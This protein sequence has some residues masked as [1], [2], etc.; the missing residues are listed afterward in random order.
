MTDL[1]ALVR[2]SLARHADAAAPLSVDPAALAASGRRRRTAGRLIAAAAC[3]TVLGLF[4]A[5]LVNGS[6]TRPVP[7]VPMATVD[8]T[9]AG[10]PKSALERY[11]GFRTVN[12][13]AD[14]RDRWREERAITKL[15]AACMARKGFTFAVGDDDPQPAYGELGKQ[16]T[17]YVRGLSPER[18]TAFWVALLNQ[19]Q[20]AGQNQ[21]P[22]WAND[23]D[24][25]CY[26]TAASSVFVVDRDTRP[27]ELQVAYLDTDEAI[28]RDVPANA[29]WSQCMAAGGYHYLTRHDL[30]VAPQIG[31]WRDA[32]ERALGPCGPAFD[33][34]TDPLRVRL[35]NEVAE[36]YHDDLEAHL[37]RYEANQALVDA[38]Q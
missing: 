3:L 36:K 37:A 21:T 34:G 4:G 7:A 24:F 33:Q 32:L 29:A 14:A 10:R 1:D 15:T 31:R 20:P 2:D 23:P 11:P 17:A 28:K 26:P 13:E 30:D 22:T 25:G 16:N 9:Q 19:K 12:A 5:A 35:E 6:A 8:P 38:N 27:G 18:R